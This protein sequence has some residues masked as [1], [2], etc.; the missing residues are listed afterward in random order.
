MVG[1]SSSSP[2]A[3]TEGSSSTY[4]VRW[5]R[6]MNTAARC[7]TPRTSWEAGSRRPARPAGE[8]GSSGPGILPGGPE[9]VLTMRRLTRLALAA[10]V[11]D[12]LQLGVGG[13][14]GRVE[15]GPLHQ[16][17][18]HRGDDQVGRVRPGPVLR[19]HRGDL[20]VGG[21]LGETGEQLAVGVRAAGELGGVRREEAL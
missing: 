6:R 19:V 15:V 20:G 13:G 14:H 2:I 16:L 1:Q 5:W 4:G 3:T 9:T 18:H 17:L 8:A 12:V 10:G 7:R 21:R 11:E